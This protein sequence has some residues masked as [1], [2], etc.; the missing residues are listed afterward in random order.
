MSNILFPTDFIVVLELTIVLDLGQKN[1]QIAE[2]SIQKYIKKVAGYLSGELNY[3][4]V[5]GER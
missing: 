4:K 5:R 3:Y 1:C 2:V